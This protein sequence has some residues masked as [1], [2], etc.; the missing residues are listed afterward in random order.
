MLQLKNIEK[1]YPIRKGQTQ[2]VLKNLNATLPDKGFVAILG[3][4]GNGKTTLANIIAGLDQCDAGKIYYNQTEIADYDAFRRQNIGIVFQ[5]SNLIA[6]LNAVDNVIVSMSDERQDKK[7]SAIRI[8]KSLG[9]A[10][11]L[12]KLPKQ[13]SGGQQQ[14]VAIARMIAKDVDIIICDEPTGSLDSETEVKIAKIIKDIAKQKLV[15]F[16]THNLKLAETYSDVILQIKDGQALPSSLEVPIKAQKSQNTAKYYTARSTWLAIKN[17]LGRYQHTLKN[18]LLAIFI[19]LV[20]SMAIILQGDFFKR[21]LHQNWLGKGLKNA[22]LNIDK[23]ADYEQLL[24]DI[25]ALE[26]V[27]YA[28]YMYDHKIEISPTGGSLVVRKTSFENIAGNNYFS[29]IITDGRY[30]ESADEVLMSAWGAIALLRDLGIGGDRLYDQYMTGAVDSANVFNLID[31]KVFVISEYGRPRIKIVGLVADQKLHETSHILYHID[32]F[33]DLFEWP[34]QRS[35]SAVKIYKDNLYRDTHESVIAAAIQNDSLIINKKYQEKVDAVYKK[36][37]S[38]LALSKVTLYVIL[39]LAVISF[40]SLL[41]TALFERKYEIGLYRSIGY[42]KRNIMKVLALEM[43]IIG[44]VSVILVF[45]LLLI[46][47][48]VFYFKLDY[49][50]QFS[51]ILIS[52]QLFNIIAALLAIVVM[53]VIIVTFSGNKIIL[54]KSILSNI[55]DL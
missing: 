2:H 38:V 22:V 48:F 6:H 47:A 46:L 29:A 43:L 40:V 36:I 37:D 31:D 30:P 51:D 5:D 20:A 44:I 45:I 27:D 35:R 55:N 1:C 8:L 54:N 50:T 23:D 4:S 26:H 13:L 9:L 49:I 17:I 52:F 14:R 7:E 25:M 41:L 42:N 21:Y 18:V 19:M 34:F 53:L 24:A 33:T 39:I 16:I 15:I 3:S 10:D 11:C 28:S 12:K 32:G